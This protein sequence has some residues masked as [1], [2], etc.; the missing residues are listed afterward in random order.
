MIYSK[1][2]LRG[3]G[4]A[5]M[6]AAYAACLHRAAPRKCVSV[7]SVPGREARR[8]APGLRCHMRHVGDA[9]RT[10]HLAEAT[11]AGRAACMRAS[12]KSQSNIL[13]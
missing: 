4:D 2:G 5:D 6:H 10:E 1:V 13:M 7:D 9:G 3:L 11:S 12:R 8:G